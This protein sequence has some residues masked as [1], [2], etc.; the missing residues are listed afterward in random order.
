MYIKN[1]DAFDGP[2][3]GRHGRIM[4]EQRPNVKQELEAV[5]ERMAEIDDALPM[6]SMR[7]FNWG[8]HDQRFNTKLSAMVPE[9]EGVPGFNLMDHL[10]AWQFGMSLMI[11]EHTMVKHRW[12][13]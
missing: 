7:Q 13:N 12:H 5:Q 9:F 1:G 8:N 2:T 4:W 10:P 11:N 3:A 6:A